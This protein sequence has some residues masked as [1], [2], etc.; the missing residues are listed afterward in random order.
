MSRA[1]QHMGENERFSDRKRKGNQIV[2]KSEIKAIKTGEKVMRLRACAMLPQHPGSI[3][4]TLIRWLI[5]PCN[6]SSK[7]PSTRGRHTDVYTHVHTQ[8]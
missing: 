6:S 5:T 4:N 7:R 2:K 1:G 3:P 8:N